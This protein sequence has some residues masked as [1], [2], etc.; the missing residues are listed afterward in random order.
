MS[1]FTKEQEWIINNIITLLENQKTELTLLT[2]RVTELEIEK[3][4][5]FRK[6][7]LEKEGKGE[8]KEKQSLLEEEEDGK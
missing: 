2:R 4:K 1:S 5:K 7:H 6:W 8:A 3:I